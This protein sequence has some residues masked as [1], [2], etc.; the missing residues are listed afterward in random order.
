MW[1]FPTKSR[2]F[3]VLPIHMVLKGIWWQREGSL[4]SYSTE[5]WMAHTEQESRSVLITLDPMARY[6]R[7]IW[8]QVC[9]SH[10]IQ[11][12]DLWILGAVGGKEGV[13]RKNSSWYVTG[14]CLCSSELHTKSCTCLTL[15]PF[16]FYSLCQCPQCIHQLWFREYSNY[17]SILL[18]RG[19]GT[20][21]V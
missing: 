15:L 12:M 13:S 1:H 16:I 8:S 11:L 19:W 17:V 21:N 4:Q 10:T 6:K 9:S 20:R 2:S 3:I 14:L 18:V 5:S 7:S